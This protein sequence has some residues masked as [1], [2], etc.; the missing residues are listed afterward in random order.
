[1]LLKKIIAFGPGHTSIHQ[2]AFLF[3]LPNLSHLSLQVG[4]KVKHT[5][6]NATVF[7]N[8]FT[9][10]SIYFFFK[11]IYFIYYTNLLYVLT[12]YLREKHFCWAM[13]G[14]QTIV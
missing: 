4:C 3:T 11:V 7:H 14:R 2:G 6:N 8:A 13:A 9:G 1:M 12:K 10:C 5:M